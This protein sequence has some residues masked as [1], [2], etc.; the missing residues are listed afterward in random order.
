MSEE[1]PKKEEG[2]KDDKKKEEGNRINVFARLR[3]TNERDRA[4]VAWEEPGIV[5]LH[6]DRKG[7]TLN[8]AKKDYEYDGT[9]GVDSNNGQIW[10]KVGRPIVENVFEGYSGS[11]MAYGQT[12]TGKSFTMSSMKPGLEGVIMRNMQYIFGRMANDEER[13]YECHFSYL[14]IYLDKVNDLMDPTSMEKKKFLDITT[15]DNDVAIPGLIAEPCNDAE[16]F[17]RLYS[18][19]DTRRTVAKTAM[20]PESSRGH[21]CV[22]IAIKSTPKGDDGTGE[23]R[24]AKFWMIDLAGYE[25]FE[26]TK[27]VGKQREEAKCINGSLMALGGVVSALAQKQTHVPWRNSKLTRL[28]SDAIGGK[29]KSTICITLGPSQTHFSST[30]VTLDFGARAMAVKVKADIRGSMNFAALCKKLQA[31]L[32]EEIEKVFAGLEREKVLED[33]IDR[34]KNKHEKQLKQLLAGGAD[35][36]AIE[37]MLAENKAEPKVDMSSRSA[38][39]KVSTGESDDEDGEGG[40]GADADADA[41]G[42]GEP[43]ITLDEGGG[44]GAG[45]GG[46]GGGGAKVSSEELDKLRE[47]HENEVNEL[48]SKIEEEMTK[49]KEKESECEKLGQYITTQKE[50]FTNEQLRLKEEQALNSGVSKDGLEQLKTEYDKQVTSIRTMM[51]TTHEARMAEIQDESKKEIASL[52]EKMSENQSVANEE[53]ENMK[54]SL[55]SKMEEEI[56]KIKAKASDVQEKLK[57]NHNVIKNSYQEQKDKLKKEIERL[58]QAHG[59]ENEQLAEKG[60]ESLRNLTEQHHAIKKNYQEQIAKLKAENDALRAKGGNGVAH[61]DPTPAPAENG[62]SEEVADDE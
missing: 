40:G 1:E 20:N 18:D 21:A 60:G 32:A 16:T 10:E 45:G 24:H 46:G 19:G 38:P 3:P 26:Q 55:T 43:D 57:R 31:Q 6:P 17:E 2:K 47:T 58:K 25:N 11:I 5:V 35:S 33:E 41:G 13:Q 34:I 23:T 8:G 7:I 59:Q 15:K 27:C 4:E 49:L 22:M 54:E 44:G 9:F 53:Y 12:G 48:R 36:A 52:K 51:E 39:G 61:S 14:Q 28:L 42:D 37:A 29:S 62:V 56:A 50:E 30:K